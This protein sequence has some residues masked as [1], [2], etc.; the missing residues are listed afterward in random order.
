MSSTRTGY[1][2]PKKANTKAVILRMI[3]K[4]GGSA[5]INFVPNKIN[6]IQADPPL[7]ASRIRGGVQRRAQNWMNLPAASCI[8][9]SP[10]AVPV[11]V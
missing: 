10:A 6:I 11:T 5:I 1:V 8:H 4:L 9:E 3:D 2:S 7:A